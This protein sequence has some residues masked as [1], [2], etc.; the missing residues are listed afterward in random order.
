MTI[1]YKTNGSYC[2]KSLT[3]WYFGKGFVKNATNAAIAENKVS[4]KC[5]YKA[6][7]NGTG[8]LTVCIEKYGGN[9]HVE[10]R[11]HSGSR[12]DFPLLDETV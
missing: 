4:G 11:K 6:W 1:N 7:Q 10:R 12:R 9:D 5:Q 2:T 8:Y 3:E